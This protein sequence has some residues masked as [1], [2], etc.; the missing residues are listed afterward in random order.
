MLYWWTEK[1]G[2]KSIVTA[3][4]SGCLSS[5]KRI[6]SFGLLGAC[7]PLAA[8]AQTIPNAP[9]NLVATALSPF[10][11]NLSWSDTSEN[12]SGFKIERSADGT[13][14]TQMAQVS[15][16]I[17][18]FRNGGLFPG[19]TYYYRVRAYNGI[20]SNYSNTTNANTPAPCPTAVVGGG[21]NDYGQAT[22]PAGLSNVVAIAAG[23][24][25]S[26]ALQSDGSIVGWGYYYYATP[27]AGLTGV[28]AIAAGPYHSLALKNDGTVVGWGDDWAGQST[29]PAGLS[30]VVAI[31][32][33]GYHSL[34]LKSDGKVVG[35]G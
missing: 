21:T 14:F 3:Q 26:L 7:L 34:A 18:S 32:A 10:Q 24:Y 30:N 6:V 8:V 9:S 11:I 35:W 2:I 4:F 17:V 16:N 29:T 1:R 20:G 27:P 25:H 28:V 31:A 23:R 5:G 33:G 13:N 15:P 12:E 19:A 22:P